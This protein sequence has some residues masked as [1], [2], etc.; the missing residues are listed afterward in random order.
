LQSELRLILLCLSVPLLAAIWWWS[1]RRSSQAR[2]NAELRES[3]VPP[4]PRYSEAN[5]EGMRAQPASRD[6]GVPPFEPLNIRTGDFDHVPVLDGPMMVNLDPVSLQAPVVAPFSSAT[7]V[8][9]SVP[10]TPTL[11][12]PVLPES[13]A[14]PPAPAA[15]EPAAPPA[16]ASQAESQKIISIRVCA[17]A[18]T[19]WPGAQLMQALEVHG[20]AFGRYQVFHRKH[21]DG[22]SLFYLASLVE[23]GTFEVAAMPEQEFRGVTL[24]AVLPGPGE[25]MET[26]DELL[27]TAH[28]LAEQLSGSVQDGKGV[29]LSAQRAAALREEIARFQASLPGK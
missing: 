25:P 22:R 11:P 3:S 12:L 13:A 21:A 6:W 14:E 18:D 26:I 9:T 8:P 10:V 5:E 16:Q 7:P 1:A 20:L 2:G 4:E 19:R 23:P 17:P 24:F 29:A 15:A 28:G 27:N